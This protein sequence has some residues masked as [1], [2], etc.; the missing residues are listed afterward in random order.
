MSKQKTRLE[1]L[2]GKFSPE[3]IETGMIKPGRQAKRLVERSAPEMIRGALEREMVACSVG[4]ALAQAR[5]ER[6]MSLAE[7]GERLEVSR[8]RVAQLE[9]PEANLEVATLVRVADALEYDVEVTLRP[10]DRKRP[11][12]VTQLPRVRAHS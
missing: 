5:R 12:I 6:E 4:E 3:E 1:T 10:R 11:P 7:V 8:G 2:L 9:R